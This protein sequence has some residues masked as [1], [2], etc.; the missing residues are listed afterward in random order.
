MP[1]GVFIEV[2]GRSKPSLE[3]YSIFAYL[4]RRALGHTV[5]ESA[6]ALPSACHC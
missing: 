5:V 3:Q 6:P 4:Q 2:Y 1:S